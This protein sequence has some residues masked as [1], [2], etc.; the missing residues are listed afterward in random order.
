MTD[1][2]I[3]PE[4]H[5]PANLAALVVDLIRQVRILKAEYAAAAE[6]LGLA[7]DQIRDLSRELDRVRERYH[8]LLDERRA[9]RAVKQG[10]AA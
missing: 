9:E 2:T 4:A 8:A 3:V 10:R 7:L 1:R 6:L 5:Q